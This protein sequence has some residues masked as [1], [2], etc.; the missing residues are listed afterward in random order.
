M[1]TENTEGKTNFELIHEAYGYYCN[2]KI[3]NKV[4]SEYLEDLI[5]MNNPQYIKEKA[6]EILEI[7]WVVESITKQMDNTMNQLME[8][9]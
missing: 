4:V 2:Q 5:S 7:S 1:K 8:K 3:L 9:T 6:Q